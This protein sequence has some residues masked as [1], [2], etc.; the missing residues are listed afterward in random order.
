MSSIS[1]LSRSEVELG[2]EKFTAWRILMEIKVILPNAC[3]GIDAQPHQLSDFFN[4][5]WRVTPSAL[6]L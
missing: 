6:V 1:K 2:L 4:R 3:M 5:D